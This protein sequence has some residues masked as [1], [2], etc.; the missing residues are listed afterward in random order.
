MRSFLLHQSLVIVA[1]VVLVAWLL[2]D[3]K[4]DDVN[5]IAA[6][7]DMLAA[8]RKTQP[9]LEMLVLD[10]QAG[11]SPPTLETICAPR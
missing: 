7:P 4:D 2:T 3:H 1:T 5:L 11:K 8:L 6:A 9:V 10:G